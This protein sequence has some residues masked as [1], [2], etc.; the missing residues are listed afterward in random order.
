MAKDEIAKKY[1]CPA[2]GTRFAGEICSG[3]LFLTEPDMKPRCFI[4]LTVVTPLLSSCDG[5]SL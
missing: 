3:K 5:V 2:A 1:I 4:A